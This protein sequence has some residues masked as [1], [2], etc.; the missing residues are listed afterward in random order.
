M[1]LQA[2]D[3]IYLADEID[4]VESGYKQSLKSTLQAAGKNPSSDDWNVLLASVSSMANS[5]LHGMSIVNNGNWTTKYTVPHDMHSV[6]LFQRGPDGAYPGFSPDT[7]SSRIGL[8]DVNGS[9]GTV[10]VSLIYIPELKAGTVID[11]NRLVTYGWYM[12]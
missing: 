6:F 12:D 3:L 8:T 7:P 4:A 10:R 5:G 1:Y 2:P 9:S 11:Y